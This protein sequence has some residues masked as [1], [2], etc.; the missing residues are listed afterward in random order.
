MNLSF[1]L[2]KL[3]ISAL[4][5][6]LLFTAF[7]ILLLIANKGDH[8]QQVNLLNWDA[9]HYYQIAMHGYNEEY[10]TAFFPLFPL[11]WKV[12]N[13]FPLGISILNGLIFSISTSLLV[14]YY[15]VNLKLHLLLLS[16]PSLFFMFIPYTEALFFLFGTILLIGFNKNSLVLIITGLLLSSMVRPSAYVFI[17]AIFITEYITKTNIT[18]FIKRSLGFTLVTLLGLFSTV[19]IQYLYTNKWFVFFSAQQQWDNSLRIPKLPLT[20]WAGGTITRLDGTALL[21]GLIAF[22]ILIRIVVRYFKSINT[23]TISRS[24]LFSLLYLCGISLI[25]LLFRGG[26]LF[27]LNR[28][29][30]ASPYFILCFFIFLKTENF[31]MR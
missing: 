12:L 23:N 24:F 18:S 8:L 4:F 29:I 27:S 10:R 7:V 5:Y 11:L 14:S 20:S 26:S 15:K 25:V 17:P 28:F 3:F 22:F 31:K 19:L 16:I 13:L 1:F 2:R 9:A 21:V 6:C 30:Y